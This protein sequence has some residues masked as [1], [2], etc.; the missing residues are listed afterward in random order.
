MKM[1][2]HW[3]P[4]GSVKVSSKISGAVVYLSRGSKTGRPSAVGYR[5]AGGKMMAFNYSF[6]SDERRAEYVAEFLK[7]CDATVAARKDRAAARKADMAKPHNLKV[8]D[9]LH[10]S[11]GY[12][13]TNV[14]FWEVT[15]LIGKRMVEIRENVCESI[16]TGFMS[17]NAV[18]LAGKFTSKAAEVRR[19]NE[20][21]SV[22][23]KSFGCYLSK[24]D[25]VT[26]DGK[27]VGYRA[28]G[29]TSYA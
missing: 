5:T 11:W 20:R 25:E 15:K 28:M 21:N 13:Q 8:G 17:G 24:A 4:E 27:K 9:V 16:E 2:Y 18:P 1:G 14:E 3:R 23:L 6:K 22:K 19:V 10:G 29:W 7:G 26:V 12:D